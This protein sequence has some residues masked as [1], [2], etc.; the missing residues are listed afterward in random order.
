MQMLGV[1]FFIIILPFIKKMLSRLPFYKKK[2]IIIK[3]RKKKK[4]VTLSVLSRPLGVGCTRVT[5][6]DQLWWPTQGKLLLM[7]HGAFLYWSILLSRMCFSNFYEY[8]KKTS[9]E[10]LGKTRCP[11]FALRRCSWVSSRAP[12]WLVSFLWWGW[13]V[14]NFP[15]LKIWLWQSP[16]SLLQPLNLSHFHGGWTS[17]SGN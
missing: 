4:A 7:A 6:Q 8:L 13:E 17:R 11:E 10:D 2:I 5:A 1:F 9:W 16:S 3:E 12:L 15:G 14:K